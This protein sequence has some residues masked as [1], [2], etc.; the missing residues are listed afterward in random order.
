MFRTW[1]C[2]LLISS[3]HQFSLAQS[4]NQPATETTLRTAHLTGHMRDDIVAVLVKYFKDSG[5]EISNPKELALESGV[6]DMILA[7]R[8]PPGIWVESGRGAPGTGA[9]GNHAIWLFQRIGDHAVLLLQTEAA[10][11]GPVAK[12][13]HHGMMDFEAYERMGALGGQTEVYRFDG[14]QYTSMYCYEVSWE[15]NGQKHGPH[16]PCDDR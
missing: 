6:V 10:M 12:T 1:F 13:F 11:S 15:Q 9:T 3:I 14:K 5:I 16:E 8:G 2:L 4:R 7:R